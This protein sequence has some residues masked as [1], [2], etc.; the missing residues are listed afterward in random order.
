M[1]DPRQLSF[2]FDAMSAFRAASLAAPA[3][4]TFRDM[5]EPL[6][7]RW[8]DLMVE[9]YDAARGACR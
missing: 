5:P 4:A 1:T 2:A 9:I 7:D 8:H 6:A 3:T